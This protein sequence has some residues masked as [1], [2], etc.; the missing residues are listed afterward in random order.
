MG[1]HLAP[2]PPHRGPAVRWQTFPVIDHRFDHMVVISERLDLTWRLW[3]EGQ[4]GCLMMLIVFYETVAPWKDWTWFCSA[5]SVSPLYTL[6]EPAGTTVRL[7]NDTPDYLVGWEVGLSAEVWTA[8]ISKAWQISQTALHNKHTQ[9]GLLLQVSNYPPYVV[10]QSVCELP[11]TVRHVSVFVLDV[12]WCKTLHWDQ[13]TDLCRVLLLDSTQQCSIVFALT[14]RVML[15]CSIWEFI[16]IQW[17]GGD[18]TL[19]LSVGR[20]WMTQKW[21]SASG[22]KWTQT[23]LLPQS[24]PSVPFEPG[25]AQVFSQPWTFRPAELQHV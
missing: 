14:L 25:G 20:S 24:G 1:V 9:R 2:F 23:E 15:G 18:L 22:L 7:Q 5:S 4:R 17:G 13:K 10:L 12:Y 6:W 16:N 11:Q 21:E 19:F 3:P 8:F